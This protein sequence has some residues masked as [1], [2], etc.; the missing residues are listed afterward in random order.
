MKEI[1]ATLATELDHPDATPEAIRKWRERGY[2]P[3]KYHLDLMD[4][5]AREGIQLG[6]GDLDWRPTKTKKRRAA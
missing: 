1:I 4:I 3:A 2:V 5:A 6:R